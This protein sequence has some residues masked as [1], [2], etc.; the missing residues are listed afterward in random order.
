MSC[1]LFLSFLFLFLSRRFF[2]WSSSTVHFVIGQK[3]S[4]FF[5]FSL[6][7]FGTFLLLIKFYVTQK[8]TYKLALLL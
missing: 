1:G 5:F 7:P 8:A 6:V 4:S 2:S 3:F